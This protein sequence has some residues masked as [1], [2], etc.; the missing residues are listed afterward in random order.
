MNKYNFSKTSWPFHIVQKRRRSR[1]YSIVK[2]PVHIKSTPSAS[3]CEFGARRALD[4]ENALYYLHAKEAEMYL[5]T[6]SNRFADITTE[7]FDKYFEEWEEVLKR[8][9]HEVSLQKIE[10]QLGKIKIRIFRPRTREEQQEIESLV[11][12]PD[13]SRLAGSPYFRH[14]LMVNRIYANYFD[15]LNDMGNYRLY[16]K[17]IMEDFEAHP[18]QIARN[19]VSYLGSIRGFV[20]SLMTV[21]FQGDA[22][23]YIQKIKSFCSNYLIKNPKSEQIR[24]FFQICFILEFELYMDVLDFDRA[25]VLI[26]QLIDSLG[27]IRRKDDLVVVHFNLSRFYFFKSEYRT[28]KVWMEQSFRIPGLE[29]SEDLSAY[30]RILYLIVHYEM[31]HQDMLESVVRSTYRFL[32]KRKRLFKIESVFLDFI[33]RDLPRLITPDQVRKSFIR[34]KNEI[35]EVC[36]DPFEA[37][38]LDYFDFISWLDSKITGKPFLDILR[39]KAKKP[40]D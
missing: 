40:M 31:G 17:R 1:K 30:V 22:Y 18:E 10:F 27:N 6:R 35:Q 5:L 28:A 16:S 9:V 7:Y 34:L 13:F 38:A 11:R 24:Y 14:R 4:S 2:T 21:E 23:L 20:N 3:S 29:E 33:R 36:R 39:G 19:P 37:R 25:E 26:P 32:L 8:A 12:D 15:M